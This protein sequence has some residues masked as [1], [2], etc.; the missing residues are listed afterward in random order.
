[1]GHPYHSS[2]QT[3]EDD[4]DAL[5]V[6][7]FFLAHLDLALARSNR[8]RNTIR[9]VASVLQ[10]PGYKD[11]LTGVQA[12]VISWVSNSMTDPLLELILRL[13][14]ALHMITKTKGSSPSSHAVKNIRR[15]L[16]SYRISI[17]QDGNSGRHEGR[18]RC[19]YLV[20]RELYHSAEISYSRCLISNDVR[21]A[22]DAHAKEIIRI[23]QQLK[24]LRPEG[25]KT[26]PP[27]TKLW[28]LPLVMVAIEV[29]DL[30]YRE[31][32][33]QMLEGYETVGSDHYVWCRRFVEAMCEKEDRASRRLDW[34]SVL[35]EIKDGLFI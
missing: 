34:G 28:P 4:Q 5:L 30:I 35:V 8:L 19:T 13:S 33:I 20:L 12:R 3:D 15:K 32:A 6:A 16:D 31:W 2:V 21:H 23:S 18:N 7:C 14:F 10:T 17:D 1:M 24:T 26:T 25:S 27:P 22:A 9:F 29:E 11:K